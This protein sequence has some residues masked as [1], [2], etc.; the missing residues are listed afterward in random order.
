MGKLVNEIK[1]KLWFEAS[2]F[3]KENILEL[4]GKNTNAVFL[5]IGCD[6]GSFSQDIVN[7][8]S[9]I[10]KYGIDINENRLKKAKQLGYKVVKGDL[11]K[12]TG[13]PDGFFDVVIANQVIEHIFDL[14]CFVSEI[15][16]VLKKDGYAIVSTE[17][18]NSWHNILATVFGY[19]PFSFTNI[20]YYKNKN[21]DLGK[22][23]GKFYIE[24]MSL[25]YHNEFF[26][27]SRVLSYKALL[28]L[29]QVYSFMIDKVLTAGYFPFP[30]LLSKILSKIDKRHSVFIAIKIMK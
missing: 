7:K 15:Y 18:L 26:L 23:F 17:L 2:K 9:P 25:D 24:D 22:L 13:F 11:N 1:D 4:V 12:G 19:Q 5:D 29:F 27:H 14:N 28:E 10:E 21:V 16:R 6:D 20:L 8:I 3:N 30:G